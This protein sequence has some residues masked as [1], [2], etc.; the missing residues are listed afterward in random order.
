MK[1][2]INM[3]DDLLESVMT[4]TG[5]TTKTEAIHIALK[6]IVRRAKLL[7]VLKEGM[8]LSPDELR[9]VFDPVSDPMKLR[10]GEGFTPY[11]VTNRPDQES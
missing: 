10:V 6:D 2:T 3:D 11:Q 7:N 5:A 8:G 1:I 4:I 9:N